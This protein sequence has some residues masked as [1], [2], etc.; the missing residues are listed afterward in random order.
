MRQQELFKRLSKIC[1][2]YIKK[3]DIEEDIDE[4]KI[5]SLKDILLITEKAMIE[6][7]KEKKNIDYKKLTPDQVMI[8]KR[9]IKEYYDNQ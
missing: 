7:K 9:L 8:L 4:K 2:K 6:V 5:K 3:L 1:E